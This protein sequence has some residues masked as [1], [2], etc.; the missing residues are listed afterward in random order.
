MNFLFISFKKKKFSGYGITYTLKAALQTVSWLSETFLR[1][2]STEI[3]I[4]DDINIKNYPPPIV[5][6][7]QIEVKGKKKFRGYAHI[8]IEISKGAIM[9]GKESFFFFS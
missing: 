6:P 9:R 4:L 1:K 8:N 3:K 5:R 2:C 7:F